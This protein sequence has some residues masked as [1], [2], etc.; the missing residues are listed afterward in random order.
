MIMIGN[1]YGIAGGALL[2]RMRGRPD[3]HSSLAYELAMIASAAVV[4]P[5]ALAHAVLAALAGKPLIA[6]APLAPVAE[7]V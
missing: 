1:V 2:G 7:P 6:F 5:L 3:S 4:L